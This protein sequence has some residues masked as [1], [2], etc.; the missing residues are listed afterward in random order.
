M[1]EE[2]FE[3]HFLQ[4]T[5]WAEVKK[6][7]GWKP[8]FLCWIPQEGNITL[9]PWKPGIDIISAAVL[10]LER[11][12][13]FGSF[14]TGFKFLYTPKGPLLDW[15]NSM[16]VKKVL[17]DL[18]QYTKTTGAFTMKIDPD[19]PIGWM[20][21][22]VDVSGTNPGQKLECWLD[23]NQ[24]RASREQ[25]QF[26]NTVVIDLTQNE[27]TLLKRMKQK[28]RYNIRL[29]SRKGIKVRKGSRE[30]YPQLF[31]MFAKT[32]L[33]DGFVIR[34][35]GYYY[36]VWDM[37]EKAGMAEILIAD[38]QSQPIAAVIIFRFGTKA[39]YFYGMSLDQHRE[40]MPNY[41]LQW[42]AIK[43]AKD[44]GCL[45]YDLWGAPDQIGPN[46]PMWGVYRF[47]EGLGGNLV[48]TI[49]AWDY[50]AQPIR[51]KLFTQVLPKMMNYLRFQGSKKTRNLV[52]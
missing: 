11:S 41:I 42:E 26:K 3:G 49:G 31:D 7:Y 44:S 17:S 5:Q 43:R 12:F 32:S 50:V 27:E 2:S 16:L 48:K 38:Y 30:D 47:K 29:A 52:N 36:L 23:D 1:L 25:V 6:R 39:W 22:S 4:S 40:K 14:R 15:E 9:V 20:L 24:W 13:C 37:F 28:T 10:V 18:A 21:N 51:Y 19:V 8:Q 33:R 45:T 46:D 34:E 35:P